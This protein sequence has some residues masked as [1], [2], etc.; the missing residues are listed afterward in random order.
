MANVMGR[1]PFDRRLSQTGEKQFIVRRVG[2][3]G[4]GISSRIDAWLASQCI[5]DQPAVLAENPPTQMFGLLA[6]FQARI[7][8]KRLARLLDLDRLRQISERE[9]LETKR[10][11]QL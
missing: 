11:E 10:S 2:R 4:T 5:D 7:C 8:R 9:Q 3:F 6:G 1:A